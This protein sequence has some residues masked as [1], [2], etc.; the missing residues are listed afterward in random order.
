MEEKIETGLGVLLV[1]HI[2]WGGS[3]HFISLSHLLSGPAKYSIA[4]DKIKLNENKG[5]NRS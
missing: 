5:T 3:K 1:Y 2:I 4:A